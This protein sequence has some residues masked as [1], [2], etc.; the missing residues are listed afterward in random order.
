MFRRGPDAPL[1]KSLPDYGNKQRL[2]ILVSLHRILF[3]EGRL[4]MI[5]HEL[6][7]PL[8][9]VSASER[10]HRKAVLHRHAALDSPRQRMVLDCPPALSR[11]D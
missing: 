10:V 4:W 6:D 5:H 9:R 7:Q 1:E 11:M 3:H 8:Q 2:T